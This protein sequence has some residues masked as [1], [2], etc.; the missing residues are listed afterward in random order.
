MIKK[1]KTLFIVKSSLIFLYLALTLPIPLM[2]GEN[3]KFF[4]IITFFLGFFLI[5]DVSS[6]YVHTSDKKIIYC[7]SFMSKIFGKKSW[8]IFWKDIKLIKSFPTSQGSSVHYFITNKN[9]NYLVPQR[10]ENLQDFLLLV[11]KKTGIK[12]EKFQYISPLWTYKLLI[13]LSVLMIVG[14]IVAFVT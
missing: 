4:S 12:T 9:E 7:T 8:E 5:V 11:S 6:D 10:L 1:F 2:S 14:E 3:S 13:C